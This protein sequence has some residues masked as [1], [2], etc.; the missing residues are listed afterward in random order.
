MSARGFALTGMIA[1]ADAL[2]RAALKQD[3]AHDVLALFRLVGV[4][5]DRRHLPGVVENRI[6]RRGPALVLG[7]TAAQTALDVI[8]CRRKGALGIPNGGEGQGVAGV[9]P[10]PVER[11][12]SPARQGQRRF[13]V[14][15]LARPADDAGKSLLGVY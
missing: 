10:R 5:G 7:P 2:P 1:V 8:K 14:V 15:A 6:A 3:E 13:E 11:A 12:V 4:D 9:S